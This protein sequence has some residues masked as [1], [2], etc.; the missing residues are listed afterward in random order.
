RLLFATSLYQAAL[1]RAARL[2]ADLAKVCL[3]IAAEDRAGQRWA[4]E[5][6]YRGYTSYAS[7][8]DLPQR[9]PEFA[10]LKAQLDKHVAA[11]A[12]AVDFDLGG[13]RLKL[14][15]LWINVM[16]EGGIHTGHIHPHSVVSGTY[17]VALPRGASAIRFEDPR[18]PLMM[19]APARNPKA[20]AHNQ[21]FVTVAPKAGTVLLWESWLR[22]EVLRN[23]ARGQ[24]ISVSFNYS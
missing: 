12:R 10:A 23:G 22:H 1:N 15:S 8:N 11:F 4:K 20:R 18:L 3:A 2:N 24:R 13:R 9:A 5:H 14:D 17:Y 7:L 6:G 21:T 16:P 19:A